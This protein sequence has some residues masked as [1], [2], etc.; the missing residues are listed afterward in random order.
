MS[1]H[2]ESSWS[3]ANPEQEYE[4]DYIA[5]WGEGMTRWEEHQRIIQSIFDRYADGPEEI[6][7]SGSTVKR[8]KLTPDQSVKLRTLNM[9]FERLTGK[10]KPSKPSKIDRS[11]LRGLSIAINE[12]GKL[13]ELV[14]RVVGSKE[15]SEAGTS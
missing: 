5:R 12:M 13:K 4:D 7:V 6:I 3:T 9:K 1:S 8:D 2:A 15:S 10:E 14:L 11:D